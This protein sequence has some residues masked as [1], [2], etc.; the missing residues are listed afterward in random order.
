MS[1]RIA[2]NHILWHG[3]VYHAI[4]SEARYG[5]GKDSDNDLLAI[6]ERARVITIDDECLVFNE[7]LS[8]E[9]GVD[10]MDVETAINEIFEAKREW[11]NYEEYRVE[12]RKAM[13]TF[14]ELVDYFGIFPE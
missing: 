8:G 1:F 5:I 11:T 10:L 2:N 13:I 9:L 12:R 6:A 14:D 3:E 4:K 7:L